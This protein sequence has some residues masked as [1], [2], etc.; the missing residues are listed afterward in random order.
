MTDDEQAQAVMAGLARGRT[1]VIIEQSQFGYRYIT[2]RQIMEEY[3]GW[4]E[5]E[6]R[7]VGK[8]HLISEEN[9]LLDYIVVNWAWE[10][11]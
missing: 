4:W 5:S 6:M 8:E 1:F 10:L 11:K 2:E 7:R 3:Y 9:C